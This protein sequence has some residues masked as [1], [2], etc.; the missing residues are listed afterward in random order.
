MVIVAQC[1]GLRVSEIAALQ[2]EDF[3]FER[4]QLLVQRSIVN[5]NVR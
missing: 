4:Q 5:G 2:W 1:L 3:D